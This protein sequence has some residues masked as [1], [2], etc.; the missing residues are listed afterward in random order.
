MKTFKEFEYLGETITNN[1][2]IKI[3]G[4]RR[5][6]KLEKL[7]NSFTN[8]Y[9]MKNRSIKSKIR[10]Y[11]TVIRP[12]LSYGSETLTRKK[13]NKDLTKTEKILPR[14]I[15]GPVINKE[16]MQEKTNV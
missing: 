15:Y 10:H 9:N 4:K 8:V 7:V 6:G 5:V 12:P 1:S 3:S 2:L 13:K 16:R 11:D 14:V